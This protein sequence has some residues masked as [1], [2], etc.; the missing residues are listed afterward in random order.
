MDW[1]LRTEILDY[2]RMALVESQGQIGEGFEL[3]G[4]QGWEALVWTG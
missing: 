4:C 1:L 2:M 3:L